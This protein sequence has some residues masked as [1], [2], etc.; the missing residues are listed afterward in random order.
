MSSKSALP[1][2]NVLRVTAKFGRVAGG[3]GLNTPDLIRARLFNAYCVETGLG[4]SRCPNR[5]ES[6]TAR[7]SRSD[8]DQSRSKRFGRDVQWARRKPSVPGSS[9]G[10][11]TLKYLL[12]RFFYFAFGARFESRCMRIRVQVSL[13]QPKTTCDQG[14][15]FYGPGRAPW[16]PRLCTVYWS[17]WGRHDRLSDGAS[18]VLPRGGTVSASLT[19]R[20]CNALRDGARSLAALKF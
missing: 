16:H 6:D 3:A 1:A 7:N 8:R 17:V 2:A 13:S 14:I 4:G 18:A 5:I 10:R 19:L 11:P 9:P 15:F 12:I 20:E